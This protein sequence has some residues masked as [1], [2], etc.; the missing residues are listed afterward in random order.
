MSSADYW[1]LKEE[2]DR[3]RER[4][5]KALRERDEEAALREVAPDLYV[6][7]LKLKLESGGRPAGEA[8]LSNEGWLARANVTKERLTGEIMDAIAAY[9]PMQLPYP[10]NQWSEPDPQIEAGRTQA[11]ESLKQLLG[12]VT[13]LDPSNSQTEG[14]VRNLRPGWQSFDRIH[15]LLGTLEMQC[16]MVRMK[17][18]DREG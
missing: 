6:D 11:R 2:A 4:F 7:F 14:L 10:L 17:G 16:A 5:Y 1:R 8:P 3:S 18:D 12:W 15:S 13:G 9:Q